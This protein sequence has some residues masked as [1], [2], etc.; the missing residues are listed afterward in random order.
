MMEKPLGKARLLFQDYRNLQQDKSKNIAIFGA[1]F[2]IV[3]CSFFGVVMNIDRDLDDPWSNDPW[4][5]TLLA[6]IISNVMLL[7]GVHFKVAKL[8][9]PWMILSIFFIMIVSWISL[10]LLGIDQWNSQ[11]LAGCAIILWTLISLF[12]CF[13]MDSV[14]K[15]YSDMKKASFVDDPENVL[16]WDDTNDYKLDYGSYGE[17]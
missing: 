1:L 17:L 11:P 15:V 9:L 8:I 14:I 4:N 5:W 3:E 13:H 10:S 7:F 12:E 2:W 6:C 16:I